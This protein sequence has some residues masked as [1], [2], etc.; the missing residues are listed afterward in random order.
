M[1]QHLQIALDHEPLAWINGVVYSNR[2][3]WYNVTARALHMDL[4]VPKERPHHAPQPAV[5]FLCVLSAL[6][7]SRCESC[8]GRVRR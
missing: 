6:L 4:I 1:K 5:L 3:A 2:P 8:R 7:T